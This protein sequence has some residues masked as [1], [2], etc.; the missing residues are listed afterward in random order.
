[1]IHERTNSHSNESDRKDMTIFLES[2]QVRTRDVKRIRVG[3]RSPL[4]KV[5]SR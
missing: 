4:L 3:L 2:M 1:M 5:I